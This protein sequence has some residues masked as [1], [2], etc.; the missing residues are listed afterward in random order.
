MPGAVLG[1][2]ARCPRPGRTRT[3]SSS[4]SRRA[5]PG[6]RPARSRRASPPT[7]RRTRAASW[8]SSPTSSTSTPGTRR[9][10][11]AP[12]WPSGGRRTCGTTPAQR[13]G[14]DHQAVGGLGDVAAER[15]ELARRARRAGRSRGRAGGRCRAAARGSR[16]ARP[17]RPAPGSARR[18][19]RGRRR[20]RARSPVPRTVSPSLVEASR[21]R[22]S[23]SRRSRSPSPAWV[24]A[25]R[26][27]GHGDPAAGDQR[28]GEERRGVGQVRL[29][30]D[31][32]GAE[33]AAAP[34]PDV[35]GGV[36]DR[37]PP[38]AQHRTVIS[39]CGWLGTGGPTWRTATPVVEAGAGQQQRR[40]E[41]AG[42]A[43]RRCAT[44]P[45]RR[46]AGAVHGE[47]QRARGRR[48]RCRRRARAAPSSR[49]PIGRSPGPRVAVEG[50]RR[51]SASA[52]TGGR[53]RITVPA[54]P[55]ST[56][57]R[58]RSG[59]GVTTPVVGRIVVDARRRGHAAPAA[60]SRVSRARSGAR[61]GDGPSA[62][63][64][65][66]RARLVSDLEPGTRTT[67]STGAERRAAPATAVWGHG[68]Q[69]SLAPGAPFLLDRLQG[70]G[71]AEGRAGWGDVRDGTRRRAS[72][73]DLVE[74]FEVERR[75]A[76]RSA[77]AARLQ[78]RADQAGLRRPRAAP[79]G[80]DVPDA[81]DERLAEPARRRL[82]LLTWGLVPS[83]A[84][85]P[86]IGNRHDQRPGRDGRREAGL[87][88][89]RSPSAAACCP[90]DGYYEW[91]SRDRR[92]PP[93]RASRASSPSSSTAATAACWRWPGSTSSGAT[94]T[95]P[96]GRPGRVAVDLHR[97]HDR[98]RRRRSAASTTGCRCSCE[99]ERW[100]RVARPRP[101]RPGR[102]RAAA[103]ARRARAGSRRTRSR[104][105]STTC[106]T[107]ARA[108]RPAA[109]EE[110]A[111]PRP[112]SGRTV[113]SDRA[114]RSSAEVRAVG[115]PAGDAR[116]HVAAA[117]R[118]A[119]RPR[120]RPR[121]RRRRRDG[122]PAP[123][124]PPRCPPRR[125]G[126]AGR[127][128]VAG[129]RPPGRR[130]RPVAGRGVAGGARDAR[131]VAEDRSSSAAA[132][133]GPGWPAAPR[134]ASAPSACSRWPSRCTRRAG[135]TGPGC[136]SSTWPVAGRP[137]GAGGAGHP[138]PVR[139]PARYASPR[140]GQ[141]ARRRRAC[142]VPV[143]TTRSGCPGGGT[144]R[145]ARRPSSWSSAGDRLAR[146]AGRG[147]LA[148]PG[149]VDSACRMSAPRA[150]TAPYRTSTCAS[151][152]D[153]AA[154]GRR[155]CRPPEWPSDAAATTRQ[156]A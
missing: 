85:D 19:R 125:H 41:L 118:R 97:A 66:T 37:T 145:R 36:V 108:G 14:L 29:D 69:P 92:L 124:W 39:M 130:R 45:P 151:W 94:R 136:R 26:P 106:A 60:I 95:R 22:P 134:A 30:L 28:G 152:P 82:R 122:R 121:C 9:P 78:R 74:E 16:P 21:R 68:R 113:L 148:A 143:P 20:C 32:D 7:G 140:R 64:A 89:G 154:A 119:R 117:R 126:G 42:G 10:S 155:C 99:R 58:T 149:E 35:G 138:G 55:Q 13:R 131:R 52:A 141:P 102:R 71:V 127:A 73:E 80:G 142:A 47:R 38:L 1:A 33:R 75:A 49:G 146:H 46:P 27:A 56:P 104:P 24:R 51:P 63:A 70:G 12:A 120:A 3:S 107:T 96:G 79:R 115:T 50:D 111:R 34:P 67:A 135:R 156:P 112:G 87:P 43:R 40:D 139:R 105:R 65:R 98:R 103:R 62:S 15:V 81:T 123:R 132:A 61:S 4:S 133:P 128:A 5:P 101:R 2:R 77:L 53:K 6:L 150:G 48:R 23:R 100:R 147:I 8:R 90:A 18:R 11:T 54:R 137:T 88:A 153:A 57:G 83:W 17:A 72:P 76:R 84:K 144:S 109:A 44:G 91:Y 110:A 129:R 31:V 59:L 114:T 93:P 86:A 25:R 116:V